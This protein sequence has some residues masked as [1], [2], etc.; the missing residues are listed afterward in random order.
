MR[1][2]ACGAAIAYDPSA[3]APKCAFCA[4]VMHLERIEDP[5]EQTEWILPFAVGPEQAQASLRAWMKTLGWY[6]PGDLATQSTI[7]SLR[8]IWWAAWIFDADALVSWTADSDYGNRRSYWAPHAGQTN[9][10]F[11]RI[12]VNA[13]RGLTIAEAGRLAG[14]FD[15]RTAGKQPHGPPGTVLESFDVQRSAARKRIA[16]ACEAEA[17]ARVQREGHIPGSRFRNVRAAVV[18]H[19]LKTNR[20]ALPVWILAYRYGDKLYRA[21]VHGQDARCV[22]GDAPISWMKITLLVL[23]IIAGIGILGALFLLILVLAA[24][25]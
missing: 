10:R 3:Q 12:L 14:F 25:S 17:A 24:N 19:G 16:D 13:S 22:F 7:D 5:V 23:A 18:L 15:L 8:P 9:M 11:E 20:M 4:S 21:I 1:C 2:D 6:R